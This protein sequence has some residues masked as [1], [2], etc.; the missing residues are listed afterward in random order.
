MNNFEKPMGKKICDTARNVKKFLSHHLDGYSLGDGQFGILYE[1]A[2]NEGISQEQISRNRNVDKATI[3]KA[4]KKL[5]D[6][7]YI[8]R[9]KDKFDKRAY[10]LYCTEKGINFIPEIRRII[11]LENTTVTKGFTQEERD[12]LSLLL[13][14]ATRNIDEYFEKE[15]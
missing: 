13:E 10:C 12:L 9:E 4:V 5:I 2:E 14:K 8:Y 6:N 7:D 3:A 1:I 15:K 11:I